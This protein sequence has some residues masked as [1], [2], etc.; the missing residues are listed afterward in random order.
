MKRFLVVSIL[1]ILMILTPGEV[2][3]QGDSNSEENTDAQI[4]VDDDYFGLPLCLPG[5]PADGSCLLYGPAQVVHDMKAAGFTYPPRALPAATPPSELGRM[6]VTV[7]RINTPEDEPAPIFA[8]F[9]D[10]VARVNPARYL[11][12]GAL[13][14]VRFVNQRND[15][16]GKAYVQLTTGEWMRASPAAYTNFQGLEFFENPRNSFGWIVD[17]ADI[18]V[19]PSFRAA[20]TGEL[21]YPYHLIQVYDTVEAEG[22]FWYKIRP[23]EWVNSQKAR[24]VTLRPTPPEGVTANRWIELNLFQQ[25]ISVYEDGNLVFASLITSGRPP[26]YTRPG[27][28]NIREKIDVAIM[29]GSFTADRSDYY[30]LEA[31]PWQLYFDG[32]IALHTAYWRTQFGYVGSHGCVNLSPGDAQWVYLWANEGD[33]VWVH[34]PSGQTPTDPS[35]FGPAGP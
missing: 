17:I 19:S 11:D 28:F 18:Y 35:L 3:A 20:T 26:F 6:P 21:L 16:S 15:S 4:N 10:A 30:H 25:T 32:S 31:V 8:S 24:V 9:E 12:R 23:G 33:Y 2:F 22:F 34:D 14:F 13:R 5:M 7:A 27:V 1:L 29:A